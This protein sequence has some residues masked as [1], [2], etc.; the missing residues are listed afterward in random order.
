[1][2]FTST[3]TITTACTLASPVTLIFM[4]F[5]RMHSRC[6]VHAIGDDGGG[7]V[8]KVIGR[9]IELAIFQTPSD[10]V[11]SERQPNPSK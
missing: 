10:Q 1:M 8:A 2:H 7:H 6:P 11:A 5:E 3:A 4:L 9:G